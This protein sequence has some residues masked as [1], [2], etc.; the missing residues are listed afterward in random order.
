MRL[1]P[2][3]KKRKDSSNLWDIWDAFR[4]V[5]G[6]IPVVTD[7]DKDRAVYRYRDYRNYQGP[8]SVE[9]ADYEITSE[10]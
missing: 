5:N 8:I 3:L 4:P 9:I 1:F 7:R 10:S 2:V 6:D